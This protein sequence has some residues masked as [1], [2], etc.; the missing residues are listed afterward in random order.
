MKKSAITLIIAFAVFIAGIGIA[1][2]VDRAGGSVSVQDVYY[3]SNQD[4]SL[5][6]ARIYRPDG[7]TNN[8]PR[9]GVIFF[10]GNDADS[11]KYSS[12]GV[13]LSRRGYVVMMHDIRGQG[14]SIGPTGNRG[15]GDSYGAVEATEYLQALSFVD[16]KNIMIGGHSLGGIAARSAYTLMPEGTYNGLI[17]YGSGRPD[18]KANLLA[19][20]ATDDSGGTPVEE[21]AKWAGVA[22]EEWKY[23]KVYGSFS[24]RTA[25]VNYY[26]MDGVHN[27]EYMNAGA[28]AITSD[29]VQSAMPI[30]NINIKGSSQVWRWRYVGT[31]IAFIAFIF[32]ILPL[33][34]L[35][36][37]IPFFKSICTKLPEYRG[38]KGKMWWIFA[39]ITAVLAPA[40]YFI[41]TKASDTLIGPGTPLS[42]VFPIR[43]TSMTMGWTVAIG[44]ITAVI[45]LV[46]HFVV[47]KK[48]S[49]TLENY[50]L[51]YKRGENLINIG[52]SLL[53]AFLIVL[54]MHSLLT[55]TYR[56][57]IIDVRIWN[58]SF[59]ALNPVRVGRV[60]VYLIP[61]ILSYLALA[62]NMHG[63]LRPKNGTLSIAKEILVN[64]AILAPWYWIYAIWLGP[65]SYMK[66][67]H[68]TTWAGFLY[69]FFWA[70]PITL[71]IIATVSTYFF[72]KT[73]KVYVGA[74]INGLLVS[75]TLLGGFSLITE[76]PPKI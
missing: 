38:N 63:T 10:P 64:V 35:M 19:V 5:L 70:V 52:K 68:T 17:L 4:G 43:R 53:F 7:A 18:V 56:W 3:T 1:Y 26:A 48:N 50:G 21:L 69:A 41:F 23:G 15:Q 73:G 55:V 72:R 34:S 14:H 75:W 65:F 11:D 27:S 9:P 16:S 31:T 32:M 62:V 76:I 67:N 39:V 40:T 45:L 22:P 13:E 59:R 33:G 66:A 8:N 36:L 60:L 12:I 6:H 24:D 57:T 49:V 37:Q 71:A 51:Q 25:K 30:Q 58:S 54:I 47:Q 46:M 61:F 20:G 74:F 44:I 42:S 28:L 29:F 2:I